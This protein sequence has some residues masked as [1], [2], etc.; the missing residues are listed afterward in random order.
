MNLNRN[1]DIDR[2]T[3]L[4]ISNI[5]VMNEYIISS[6]L[7]E[8]QPISMDHNRRLVNEMIDNILDDNK[9]T[10][11]I[12]SSQCSSIKLQS[13]D[14][15]YDKRLKYW[16]DV[17]KE[18]KEISDKIHQKTNKNSNDILYNRT[19]TIDE[20]DKQTV[21]RLLDY[22]HRLNPIVLSVRKPSVLK[23]KC[24]LEMSEEFIPELQE[25]LPQTEI[26]KKI[27]FEISGLPKVTQQEVLGTSQ[28]QSKKSTNWLKSKHLEKRIEEMRDD[29]EQVIEYYPDIENLQVLGESFLKSKTSEYNNE[30]RLMPSTEVCQISSETHLEDNTCLIDSKSSQVEE[31]IDY[32]FKINDQIILITNKR[33]SSNFKTFTTFTCFPFQTE[34][35]KIFT[36]QNIGRK[37]LT[38]EWNRRAFY[39]KNWNLLKSCDNEFLFDNIPFRLCSG[40][41]KDVYVMFQPRSVSIVKSKWILEVKPSFFSRKLE[42]IVMR[43]CG[44]CTV[45]PE[46][47]Q[48]LNELQKDVIEK[49]NKKMIN[50]LAT[51]LSFLVTDLQP[52]QYICPYQRSLNEMELF[53][54]LNCGFKCKRYNDLELLKDLYARAKK[55]REKLWDLKVN[56]LK[57][58]ILKVPLAEARAFMFNELNGILNGMKGNS[59]DLETKLIDSCERNRN[60]LLYV[61]GIINTAI[62]DW[63][64]L[65]TTL[66]DTFY[67]TTLQVVNDEIAEM[68]LNLEDTDNENKINLILPEDESEKRQYILEKRVYKLKPFRDVL[69]MQTYSILCDFVENIVNIIES[70]EIM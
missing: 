1:K 44:I 54:Q 29:I 26:Q 62:E 35:K 56:T 28:H 24:N 61:R 37:A 57:S 39:D 70:N 16:K 6:S 36:I 42:G 9:G 20:R 53:E 22:S 63:V 30:I 69:Y 8:T 68:Q 14:H 50:K 64:E 43:L 33:R 58:T 67:Q 47:E 10:C 40:E 5:S 66:E 12:S 59:L 52:N 32:G 25:T 60:C 65:V 55:P 34:V 31:V 2:A 45:P 19:T 38:F 21:K 51:G 49:S 46:Y 27:Q 3:M 48:T 15:S 13:S 41:I 18:R 7:T 4:A 17:L 11:E 23:E